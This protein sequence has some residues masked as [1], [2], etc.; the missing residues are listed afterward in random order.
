MW[1]ILSSPFIKN[2]ILLFMN[3]AYV[4]LLISSIEL[5]KKYRCLNGQSVYL[6]FRDFGLLDV[7]KRH[8]DVEML[9]GEEDL[10]RD[11]DG[12]LASRGGRKIDSLPRH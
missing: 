4:N 3:S 7:L 6:M 2:G 8:K 10:I 1:R 12:I 11:I 5:Y 9:L